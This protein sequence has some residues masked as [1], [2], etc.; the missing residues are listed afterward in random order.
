MSGLRDDAVATLLRME[1]SPLRDRYV[2]HLAAHERGVYRDCS[3]DHV[4]ASTLVLSADHTRVLLTLHAK[5]RAWF[6]FGGH[7]EEGDATLVAAALREA[8]EESG[9]PDLRVDPVPIHLDE[10]PVP[11]CGGSR[12]ARPAQAAGAE[13]AQAAGPAQG[14]ARPT[15][16]GAEPAQQRVTHHLDVRF[17]AV[18][19][20]DAVHAVSE[21]SVDVR[22]W[23]VDAL[24]TE[25][26]S[27][28]ALV[29]SALVRVGLQ[30]QR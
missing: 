30:P 22:W 13:P 18:A 7:C 17:L 25:E 27:M 26:P 23:P 19:D 28:R 4:T 21:E 20:A 9:L 14:E 29:D 1:P 3:P 5:A 10:H 15:Q 2:E 11:F 16:A 12:R 24:P 6:Q 8:S